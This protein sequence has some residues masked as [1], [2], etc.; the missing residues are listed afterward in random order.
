MGAISALATLTSRP[1]GLRGRD[2]GIA[3][4]GFAPKEVGRED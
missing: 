1:T 3:A 2:F 4:S